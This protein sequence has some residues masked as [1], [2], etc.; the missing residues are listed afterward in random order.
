MIHTKFDI[1]AAARTVI[2]EARG[3]PAEGQEAIA[4]VIRH[5]AI[6]GRFGGPTLAQVCLRSGRTPSGLW[7]PQFACWN[8]G[9]PNREFIGEMGLHHVALM[10]AIAMV[11]RVMYADL[12]LDPIGG[13][14]HYAQIATNP[15][16]AAGHDPVK[17]IGNHAFYA[18]IR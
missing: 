14:T 17:I 13:A 12:G 8:L 5:R 9:D 10:Q 18:N 6:A 3:E 15:F 4:W 7:V 16:W 1:E 2:G 11:E